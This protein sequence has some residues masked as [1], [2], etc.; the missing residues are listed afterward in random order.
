LAGSIAEAPVAALQIDD[1]GA[2]L[3]LG[4]DGMKVQ[5]ADRRDGPGQGAQEKLNGRA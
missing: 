1:A 2:C 3:R 5:L 4:R